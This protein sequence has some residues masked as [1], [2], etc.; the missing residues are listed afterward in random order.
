MKVIVD[1]KGGYGN[2]L[3]CY[4]LGYAVSKELHA[5]LWLDTSMLDNCIVNGRQA[6]IFHSNILY[7]KRISYSYHKNQII[8]KL[9]INRFCKKNAIGW[10]TVV[11]EEKQ[12]IQYDQEVFRIKQ[13]TYF[14]GF[15]QNPRYFEQYR[16]ELLTTLQPKEK[17]SESV[18]QLV[19]QMEQELSVS[20]HIR[21]GDYT[22]LGWNLPMSYYEVA[23]VKIEEL[24]GERPCYYIFSDDMEYAKNY[25]KDSERTIRYISYHSDDPVR[26]DMFLMSKCRHNIIA[27]SSYSWWGAYQN[28]YQDRKV[29]C[30]VLGMWTEEFY[31]QDWYKIKITD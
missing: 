25:Y 26:D 10:G 19:K 3:F 14:D 23:M 20:V 13:D 4:A 27:N 2:Q 29:I 15:W 30:P 8:R 12:P 22:T 31:P 16:E 18:C 5:D 17:K 1:I 6:E 21:R 28:T 7:D 11:Y 9:G 24:L